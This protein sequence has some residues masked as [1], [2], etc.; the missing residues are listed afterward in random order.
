MHKI[1]ETI[2]NNYDTKDKGLITETPV[3]DKVEASWKQLKELQKSLD[4]SRNF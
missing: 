1:I 4:D 2:T 3:I